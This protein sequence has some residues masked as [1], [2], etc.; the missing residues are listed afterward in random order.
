MHFNRPLACLMTA[1]LTVVTAVTPAFAATGTVTATTLNIRSEGNTTSS[2]VGKLHSGDQ[3]EVTGVTGDS[4]YQINAGGTVG[5]VSGEYLTVAAEEVSG[6]EQ[7][8]EPIYVK[9]T[10]A[11]NLNIR[12]GASTDTAKVGSLAPGSVVKALEIVDGWYRL[13]NGYISG[14]YAAQ[15]DPSEAAAP[16]AASVS[17]GR[18]QQVANLAKQFVG[19]RYVH[20]GSSPS[21]FDCS[22][23]TSYLYR[24]FGVNISRV[25]AG[26]MSSGHKVSRSE[27]QPGDIIAFNTNGRGISHVGLYIGNGQIIHA[28]NP[29]DGVKINNLSSS[30]YS[31]RYVTAVRIFD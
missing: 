28:S 11:I 19:Y 18:G 6:L 10:S 24:Q 2:I 13:E 25:P 1:A 14:D 23:F 3:V 26:Q 9:V 31:T 8:Q 21:G 4:W 15:C 22:G 12:E 20:G 30:Y 27:L 17:S 5:F 29:S 7:I 16:A